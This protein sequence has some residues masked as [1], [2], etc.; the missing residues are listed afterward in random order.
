M[1]G[2][3]YRVYYTIN[4]NTIILLINGGDKKSQLKDIKLAK[5]I[6]TNLKMKGI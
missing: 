4:D 6:T 1:F 2:A 5:K 3:G